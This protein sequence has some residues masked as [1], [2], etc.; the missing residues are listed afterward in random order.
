MQQYLGW[1]FML[2][3]WPACFFSFFFCVCVICVHVYL[4][5]CLMVALYRV[6]SPAVALSFVLRAGH[7]P[8][9]HAAWRSASSITAA[10]TTS[11]SRTATTITTTTTTTNNTSPLPP[12]SPP[13]ALLRAAPL[14]AVPVLG[15]P[16]GFHRCE[17]FGNPPPSPDLATAC[18]GLT[19]FLA[20]SE[21][22]GSKGARSAASAGEGHGE[23][24]A[25]GSAVPH[26][27]PVL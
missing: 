22:A 4:C 17:S 20:L 2:L 3:F 8:G 24:S 25:R 27:C 1:W 19:A 6:P 7:G 10:T 21:G 23:T 13:G 18:E 5:V 14:R 12:G 15:L 11:R 16:L 9:G 26:A